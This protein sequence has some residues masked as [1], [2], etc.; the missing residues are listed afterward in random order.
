VKDRDWAIQEQIDY[1]VK[2][3]GYLRDMV[4]GLTNEMLFACETGARLQDFGVPADAAKTLGARIVAA[5]EQQ[6]A[7]FRK[8]AEQAREDAAAWRKALDL[9]QE[10]RHA[11]R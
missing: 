3:A 8:G 10:A 2:R 9:V 7:L 1:A 4:D 6:V 11:R 5:Q